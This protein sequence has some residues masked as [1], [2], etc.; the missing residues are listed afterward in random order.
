MKRIGKY[1]IFILSL[2][3]F[4][5]TVNAESITIDKFI[6]TIENGNVTSQFKKAME[7]EGVTTFDIKVNKINEKSFILSYNIVHTKKDQKKEPIVSTYNNSVTFNY[8][9]E[10]K[11]LESVMVIERKEKRDELRTKLLPSILKLVPAWTVESSINYENVKMLIEEGKEYEVLSGIFNKC[12]MEEMGTCYTD[13][14]TDGRTEYITKLELN[15]KAYEYALKAL[16]EQNKESEKEEKDL[17]LLYILGGL[18]IAYLLAVSVS[19]SMK[20]KKK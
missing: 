1:L 5:K 15:D 18:V 8:N 9:E 19:K 6:N 13:V 20:R 3:V 16:K 12:Y 11:L 10:T 14:T 2:F 17:K 4:T 7:L